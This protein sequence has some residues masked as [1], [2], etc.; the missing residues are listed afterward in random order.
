CTCHLR[1][2]VNP[3]FMCEGSS[4]EDF[5]RPPITLVGSEDPGV[6]AVLRELY[7]GVEAPFVLART[8]TAEM[9]KYAAR[10]FHALE[11][12]FANE[13][14]HV[15]AA[16]GADPR[17]VVRIVLL[18][19]KPG[20]SE[21]S[22]T[23]GYA[24]GGPCLPMD[25]RALLQAAR[26]A[27]VTALLLGAILPSKEALLRRGAEAVLA[28]G[29]RRVGVVGLSYREGTDELGESPLVDLVETLVRRGRDV[30][31]LDRDVA[32]ARLTGASRR[33]VEEHVPLIASLMCPGVEELLAHAEVLVVGKAGEDAAAALAG[34]RARHVV[35]D[36][37]RGGA[38]RHASRAA[39]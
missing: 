32:P 18:D 9:V 26:S 7:G 36:L 39:A 34:V 21:A 1:V 33:Y 4:V 22:L 28:T 35:V 31:V 13:I 11:A 38:R 6:G 20:L 5:A 17:E 15:S 30:R 10:A 14:G 12:C 2:A 29:K 23:S 3:E 27:E 24:F 37:T 8:R 19:R 25:L 16:F